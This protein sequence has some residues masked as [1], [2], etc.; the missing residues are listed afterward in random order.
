MAPQ[1][2]EEPEPPEATEDI[3]ARMRRGLVDAMKA[4]DQQAVAALRSTLARID[5]A[6]AVD[7]EAVDAEPALYS[8]EG[9]PAVA[10][11]VLGVG[12][13]EVDRRVLTPEEMAALIRD[14]VEER[15]IAAEVLVRV[16]RPDQAER[17]RAQAKLLTAYLTPPGSPPEPPHGG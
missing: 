4:R 5:N 13:A 11:S 2:S 12:A 16:G 15:E 6:E 7:A 17:L 3:R 9:H 8:G 1:H 10:G 14:D